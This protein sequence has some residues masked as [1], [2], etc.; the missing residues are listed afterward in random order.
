MEKKSI[1]FLYLPDPSLSHAFFA[2]LVTAPHTIFELL[3]L[4]T[5]NVV[6]LFL[7]SE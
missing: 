3:L 1:Y 5:D 2:R 4:S 7:F 6:Y